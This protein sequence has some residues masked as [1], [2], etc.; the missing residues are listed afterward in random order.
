MLLILIRGSA[1]RDKD[2]FL[3]AKAPT[4]FIYEVFILQ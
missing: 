2:D 4:F 3:G 1:G